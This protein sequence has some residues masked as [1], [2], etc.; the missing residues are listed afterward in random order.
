MKKFVSL[1]LVM[2]MVLSLV[3]CGDTE[4]PKNPVQGSGDSQQGNVVPAVD[5]DEIVKFDPN[6]TYTYNDSVSTLA[7]NWNPHVYQTADDA[8]PQDFIMSSL[9]TMVF[10]DEL[11]PL[12]GREA[13]DGYVIIPE[14]AADYPVDV[15]ESVKASHPQFNIPESATS[16][17]AWS[18]KLRDDLKWDDGTPITAED[19]VESFK[20]L[21]DPKL[22][23][24]RAADYADGSY[25]VVGAMDYAYQGKSSFQP[26]GKSYDE[27]IAGGGSDE[28]L[29]VDIDGFWGITYDDGTTYGSITD[30]TLIRDPAVPEG[31]EED[32]VSPKYLWE[33]YLANGCPYAGYQ[34]ELV[35]TLKS[36]A[37]DY[38]YDNVGLYVSGDNELTFVYR[39]ALDGFYLMTY[40]M[41]TSYLVKIDLYD[42]CLTETETASGSVW[43]STY[44]TS[45]ATSPS[46][47]PY[48][49]DSFQT[50]K[51]MHFTKNDNW[52]GWNDGN[53]IYV[54][55]DDGKVYPMYQTTDIDTQ[56]VTEA[57]TRKQMFFAG[58]LMGY[59]LQADDFDQYIN[60]D[61]CYKTPAETIFFFLFNGF[62]SVIQEREAAADFDQNTTDIEMQ[63]LNSFRRAV[64]VSVD[65][66]DLAATCSPARK[67]GYAFLGDTYIYD[68]ETAAYYR[69]T[70][71]AKQVLCDFYSINVDDFG[72]DLDAAVA[73]ITGFD[74]ETGKELFQQ[75]YEEGIELG[76]I[77][78]NDG[79]G[80]SDQVVTMMYAASADPSDMLKKLQAYLNDTFDKVTE[81]TGLYQKIRIE[82][83]APLGNGWSD[84]LRNGIYDTQLA[85]WSGGRLDPFGTTDTWTRTD[86]A[87]WGNWWDAK[88]H[89]MT[90]NI[91]GK[92]LTM[93][94]RDFAE[95]LNGNMK[96]VD[97]V[98]YNFGYGQVDVETRLDI[99]AAIEGQML[100]AYNCVPI[101]QDASAALFTQKAYYIVEE[102]NPMM[103][104]GGISYMK[105]NYSDT[106]WAD[107]VASQGGQLQY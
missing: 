20:R 27:Y 24:F 40:A 53:H 9:Y 21:L 18:V 71:Q 31:E 74:P 55:P 85:G 39:N 91:D 34:S 69:D 72:G 96:T 92:D 8:Y 56:V 103:S 26:L 22:I 68:P 13:Y 30:E 102:Y 42:E 107:Y 65:R 82:F 54:D 76:Y 10:N 84:A 1:L 41:S 35:G 32:Y 63:M 60:S 79:D 83:T 70:P 12:E 89:N 62:E 38:S 75:A 78:D 17:Y 43:S 93:S 99:L 94:V 80:L 98:D 7:S 23:N 57:A 81:G 58:Q 11:H 15:T 51:A 104:R 29:Y 4:T 2:A 73:S 46:Y 19:F 86:S 49:M 59:G 6:E 25:A 48:I 33:T 3:A 14:M 52:F 50:D 101:M 64:A 105:Y 87:Y 61:Y 16:G 106:E 97:G 95:C 66:E 100:M 90:V 5:P 45:V 88:K 36:Y 47:G 44:M 77:T 67:G 37:D 28:D